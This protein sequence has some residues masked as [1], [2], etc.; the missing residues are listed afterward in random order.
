MVW[1]EVTRRRY[2]R[3]TTRYATDMTDREWG[4]VQPFQPMPLRLGR[5][6][7]TDLR[8]TIGANLVVA[9]VLGR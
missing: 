9:A 1:T 2:A 4:L 7:P 8:V 3:R 6:R 5:P